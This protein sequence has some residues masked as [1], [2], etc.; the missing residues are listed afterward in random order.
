M[1]PRDPTTAPGSIEHFRARVLQ[2][3]LA[4][5]TAG[6]WR[7]RADQF[8]TVGTDRADEIAAACRNRARIEDMYD[9]ETLTAA[10]VEEFTRW[11]DL[12][13][14]ARATEAAA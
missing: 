8:T 1:K 14:L 10:R 5:A 11:Y 2:D 3:A 6:H 9:P 13:R 7:R 4:E 12:Q